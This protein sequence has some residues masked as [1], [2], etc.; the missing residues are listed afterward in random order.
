[1][2]YSIFF[3]FFFTFSY[4]QEIDKTSEEY[5]E[6]ESLFHVGKLYYKSKIYDLAKVKTEKAVKLYAA[7]YKVK[8]KLLAEI[9][10]LLGLLYAY[11]KETNTAISQIEEAL[12]IFSENKENKENNYVDV[13]TTQAILGGLY[14]T[15][16]R[17]EESFVVLKETLNNFKIINL[18]SKKIYLSNLNQLVNVSGRIHRED[19]QLKY[20][21]ESLILS[22]EIYGP[23]SINY[24]ENLEVLAGSFY[25]IKDFTKAQDLNNKALLI[26]REF[27]GDKDINVVASLQ[28]LGSISEQLGAYKVALQYYNEALLIQQKEIGENKIETATTLA[29]IGELKGKLADYETAIF[30]FK[31]SIKIFQDNQIENED[32][33]FILSC[34]ASVLEKTG[35][36]KEALK[37]C[38][39][40]LLN[41][42]KKYGGYNLA[43]ISILNS[44][45]SHYML[46]YEFDKT[47]NALKES[48]S[49]AEQ[50]VGY[51]E[52]NIF[53]ILLEFSNVYSFS[54]DYEK[55]LE[56]SD[57][58]HEKMAVLSNEKTLQKRYMFNL[59]TIYLRQN[60]FKEA[61]EI[62]IQIKKEIK[63]TIDPDYL[64]VNQRLRNVYFGLE[65]FKKTLQI[66]KEINDIVVKNIQKNFKFMS[67]DEKKNFINH[68]VQTDIHLLSLILR[69]KE[70]PAHKLEESTTL[71]LNNILMLKGLLLNSSKNVFTNLKSLNDIKIDEKIEMYRDKKI[72]V[73]SELQLAV[74]KRSKSFLEQ[75]EALETLEKEIIK[76]H[77]K[78]FKE[79]EKYQKD[80]KLTNLQENEIAIEFSH[81]KVYNKNYNQST[82]FYVAYIYKKDWKTPK[83][84]DLFEEHEL[85]TYFASAK[86]PNNLYKTRGSELSSTKAQFA[87]ADSIYKLVWQPL[88]K[89]LK[90]SKTVYFSPDGLLHKIPFAALPN[91]D[92]K[93]I[94][95]MYN[96][97]QMGN[98]ADVH[99]NNKLPNLNDA[100]L[101]G[102]VKYEYKVDKTKKKKATTYAI[103][104]GENLL[105][106][107]KNRNVSRNGFDY[108]LGTQEEITNIKAVLENS[109]QLSGYNATETA[110]KELSGKSPSILHIATHG[111]FFP[112]LEEKIN[113]NEIIGGEKKLNVAENPLLRS[114]LLFANAN[115]AWQHGNNP[116][117]KDD[118]ILTA[119]E[120]SN[121]DFKNTDIVILSACETGLG[122]IEGSEGVYGL[123]RA[124]KMAGVK[125]IIMS[126]W[127]V[128]DK[129]TAE[130]MNLFYS[131]WK[132]YNNPKKAFKEAQNQ[133]MKKYRGEPEKWAAFVY[134]E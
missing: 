52:E 59:G 100:L 92:N 65:K 64:L 133:M 130:F 55:A 41:I 88:E 51:N 78:Y 30:L 89:H 13:S 36:S 12:Q 2:I 132:T 81:Y 120:I 109:K 98:T 83:A 128:P 69:A 21:Q 86:T 15:A 11:E 9:K 16:G 5:N 129:E 124:F 134:F 1:M 31:E 72:F 126:L 28:Q 37:I 56:F 110:F 96:I 71:L 24:A 118:G 114:G 10:L 43:E 26:R 127:P 97:Q 107:E 47:L 75:K 104:Q 66:S 112:K 23:N 29:I 35:N 48:L 54:G 67:A 32:Y 119:L 101:I 94:S 22:S 45:A 131:K 60:K 73:T 7:N 122:D 68:V 19:D 3:F 111:F 121:L 50:N 70:F 123:Q 84:I 49:I 46:R 61:K 125:T 27:Y 102:G 108:L 39:N 76:I 106:D 99:I 53:S 8:T 79:V 116:Y 77:S 82:V 58:A 42:K 62:L 91:K 115:Y 17:Y 95:E 34:Y 57:K 87:V 4:A 80:W 44:I 33:Y 63:N 93:L 6:I 18:E 85:N 40:S 117:D 38:E 105:G 103:L 90:N 74:K 20:V 14:S 25:S 113:N